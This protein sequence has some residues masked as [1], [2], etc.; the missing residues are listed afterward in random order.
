MELRPPPRGRAAVT[1][2]V[3]YELSTPAF[4]SGA[5]RRRAEVRLPSLKGVLRFWWR[6]LQGQHVH[7]VETLRA[8]EAELFG[9]AD[10]GQSRVS[11]RLLAPGDLRREQWADPG[12]PIE[13]FLAAAG[14]RP[15][16]AAHGA[17]YLGYGVLDAQRG[18]LERACLR[19]PL[20][21]RMRVVL[22]PLAK[23]DASTDAERHVAVK[24]RDEIRRALVALGTL[25]GVGARS[26]K[27]FG[28]LV[29]RRL[30]CESAPA[31]EA[32]ADAEA[33]AQAIASLHVDRDRDGAAPELPEWTALSPRSRHVLLVPRQQAGSTSGLAL[34]DRLGCELV[35]FRSFGKNGRILGDTEP[36]VPR[37]RADHDLYKDAVNG[38]RPDRHPARVVFGLPHRYSNAFEV[39]PA[40]P[41]LERRASPLFVHVHLCGNVPVLVVSFLPSRFLP[42]ASLRVGSRTAAARIPLSSDEELWK[43]IRDFL[44]RLLERSRWQALGID[45]ALEVPHDR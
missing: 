40:S 37:F 23:E 15:P 45:R 36:A 10:V 31:W 16:S 9:S 8:R 17:R 13:L 6:A 38:R 4:L 32:P 26:R 41:K 35:R 39:V 44:E 21:V 29:L 14:R 42:E 12:T 22:R 11:M 33:L 2:E 5:D 27:G 20:T 3:T 25:G 18:T 7:E 34:L 19:P 30:E 24:A 1:F 43:P 28:S